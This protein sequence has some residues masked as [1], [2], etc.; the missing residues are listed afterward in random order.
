MEDDGSLKWAAIEDAAGSEDRVQK[1]A[2]DIMKHLKTVL[3]PYTGKA[4]VVCVSRRN[5][6][7]MYDALK[8]IEGCP[9][10]AVVMTGNISKTM[11]GTN[12]SGLRMQPKP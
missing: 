8:A 12:I 5:S 6:V 7:K 10:I 11:N 4:M 2:N 9:E 1:I 3:K